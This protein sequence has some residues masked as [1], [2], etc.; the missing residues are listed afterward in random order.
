MTLLGLDFDNTLVRYDNLFHRL[1]VEKGLIDDSMVVDKIGIRDYLREQGRDDEFTML[2]GEVYGLRILD[3]NPAE[4]ML[5]ALDNLKLMGIPMV[6]VS[7]KT[8]FPYKGPQYDLHQAAMNWLNKNSFFSQEGLAWSQSQ[9]HF[10]STKENKIR[11]IL[12]LGC[13]HYVDDLPEIIN[14]LPKSVKRILYS[15]GNVSSACSD[16]VINHWSDLSA[17]FK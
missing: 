9:I 1:A 6:L 3:A 13:T 4:G 15:P 11:K 12:S 16:I 14:M 5:N 8:R 2:Q 7:H 17:H 10:E